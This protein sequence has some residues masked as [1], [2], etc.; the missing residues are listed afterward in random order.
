MPEDEEVH[1]KWRKDP[2]G[3]VFFGLILI[4]GAGVYLFKSYLPTGEWWNWALAGIGC[5]FILEALVRSFIP[6][7]K[8]P[9]FGRAVWG[10]IFIGI[11]M[12]FAYGFEN[13]WPYLIVGVGVIMLLYYIR[14]SI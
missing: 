11:G 12:G 10:V 3:G 7:Y 6:Q 8:R 9:S 4:V 2:L 14:K 1:E 13:F 5:V